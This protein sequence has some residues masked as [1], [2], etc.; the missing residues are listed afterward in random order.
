MVLS[1]TI[2]S[3]TQD[4]EP[5][6]DYCIELYERGERDGSSWQ[7]VHSSVYDMPNKILYVIP[8]ETGEIYEF[9]LGMI[10]QEAKLLEQDLPV[11]TQITLKSSTAGSSKLFTITVDDSGNLSATEKTN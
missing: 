9:R 2:D 7:T 4:F 5:V 3:T 8:Q 11:L 10:G 6:V 1:Q